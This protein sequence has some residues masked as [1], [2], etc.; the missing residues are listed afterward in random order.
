MFKR[1][2]LCLVI[3]VY[4]QLGMASGKYL[5]PLPSPSIEVIN[6]ESK[7]CSTSCLRDFLEK[8]QVF[9]FIAN[10]DKDNQNNAIIAEL[11]AFLNAFEI[12]EIPYFLGVQK[13]FFSIALMFPRKSVGRYSSTTTNVILSY[14]LSQKGRFNFEIFDSKTESLENIQEALQEIYAKGYRQII[15]VVTQEGANII[16]TLNPDMLVFIPTVHKMQLQDVS[17]PN[18]IFGGISYKQQIQKL[19]DLNPEVSAVSFYDASLIGKQMQAYTQEANLNLIYSQSF[20][21]KQNPNFNKEIKNLKSTLRSARVFLNTPVANSS[22]ILSQFTYNDIRPKALYSTQINYNPSL[23][24][25]T[26]E[27]DRANM[28]IANS[29]M[30]LDDLFIENAKFLNADLEY[31]WINYAT[32]LGVEYFYTKSVSR[33]KR[34]FKEKIKDQQVQ[35]NIEILQ[36]TNTR[37]APLN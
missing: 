30:P 23:L 21:V 37:F 16:N 32:A 15:A 29:I 18:I 24:S 34:Y 13:P 11:N 31:N 27:R 10:V 7:T 3:L 26:Q 33:A 2:I 17:A 35:Y 36:P 5:S 1:I 25:I 22:I 20:N 4:P 6:L 14:L 12:S 9:S 8:G 28:Y 19:S